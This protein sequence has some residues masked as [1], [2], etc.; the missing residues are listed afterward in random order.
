MA[1]NID[2]GRQLPEQAVTKGVD[3]WLFQSLEKIKCSPLNVK[4]NRSVHWKLGIDTHGLGN[5]S[6]RETSFKKKNIW[7]ESNISL[8]KILPIDYVI[9]LKLLKTFA[10]KFNDYRPWENR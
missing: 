10:R 7:T 5:I 2:L 9:H 4:L 1:L 8:G 3:K 6:R